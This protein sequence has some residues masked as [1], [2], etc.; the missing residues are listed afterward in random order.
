MSASWAW[1]CKNANCQITHIVN[2]SLVNNV[3]NNSAKSKNEI[4]D[5]FF[6]WCEQCMIFNW[7]CFVLSDS[8][9]I[10]Q[11]RE[12]GAPCRCIQASGQPS[13][14]PCRQASHLICSLSVRPPCPARLGNP[15]STTLLSASW[16]SSYSAS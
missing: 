3:C 7:V 12:C 2:N 13:T 5:N 4:I 6:K 11:C 16:H 8:H 1:L 9:P 15:F 14:T 10:L